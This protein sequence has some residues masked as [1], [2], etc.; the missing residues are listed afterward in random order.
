[1]NDHMLNLDEL[2]GQAR[3]VVV[4]YHDKRF[5]FMRP[6]ALTP[7]Q[8]ADWLALEG[9]V[10]AIKA[11]ESALEQNDIAE[12]DTLLTKI[13]SLLCPAF[14]AEEPPFQVRSKALEFYFTE[15]FP[16]L[17]KKNEDAEKNSIGAGHSP[18]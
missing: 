1:M 12:W 8:Y 6:E 15:A 14:V 9:K 4:K 2:F 5:E 7:A 10:E 17:A 18:A 13:I 3:P 11:K 16:Q